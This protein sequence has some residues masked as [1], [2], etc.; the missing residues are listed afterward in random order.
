MQYE[1][2]HFETLTAKIHLQSS[3]RFSPAKKKM[4]YV[5]NYAFCI[6]DLCTLVMKISTAEKINKFTVEK[7]FFTLKNAKM[8]TSK[9]LSR[10]TDTVDI[11]KIRQ[12][13]YIK[14]S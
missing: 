7:Y 1:I 12:G 4:F 11:V 6:Q 10:K 5:S 13:R 2:K 14:L 9:K 8:R 3:F